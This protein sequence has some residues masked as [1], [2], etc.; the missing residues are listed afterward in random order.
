MGKFDS[1]LSHKNSSPLAEH[2][3]KLIFNL[4]PQPFEM[5]AN[6]I[7]RNFQTELNIFR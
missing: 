4:L 1:L 3:E 5:L 6:E 7:T 2:T